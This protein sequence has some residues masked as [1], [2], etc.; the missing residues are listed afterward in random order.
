MTYMP[1]CIQ[2][3]TNQAVVG[4]QLGF[5]CSRGSLIIAEAITN[6]VGFMLRLYCAV[7]EGYIKKIGI[8]YN[9]S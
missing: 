9:K 5:S 8:L 1:I 7:N 2:D 4:E 6:E 3:E